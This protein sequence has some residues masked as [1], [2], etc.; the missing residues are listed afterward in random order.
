MSHCTVIYWFVGA[1]TAV[2]N[3]RC[4]T[5]LWYFFKSRL[6]WRHFSCLPSN[7]VILHTPNKFNHS[8]PLSHT[9]THTQ[10]KSL[11]T[12]KRLFYEHSKLYV[13]CATVVHL[14]I[15]QTNF[16][17]ARATYV[18]LYS[19]ALRYQYGYFRN[20]DVPF[21]KV[22]PPL[23]AFVHL[24][25]RVTNKWRLQ[26]DYQKTMSSRVSCLISWCC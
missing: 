18:S 13:T 6:V 5:I 19:P 20:K 23:T 25:L 10:T 9:H 26:Q 1:R 16:F 11:H 15:A 22:L 8:L 2:D 3:V 17:I 14:F 21:E 12:I 24:F 4:S 7:I